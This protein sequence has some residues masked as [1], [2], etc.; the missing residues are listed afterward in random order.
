MGRVTKAKKRTTPAKKKP[1]QPAKVAKIRKAKII[2][3]SIL[4]A[5]T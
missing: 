4:E 2:D 1:T 5:K 3:V